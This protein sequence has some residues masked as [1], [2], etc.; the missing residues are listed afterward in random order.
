MNKNKQTSLEKV[1]SSGD[2]SDGPTADYF[3]SSSDYE[4]RSEAACSLVS[5]T[6]TAISARTWPKNRHLVDS[7]PNGE[8]GQWQQ[9]RKSRRHEQETKK[10]AS[11]RDVLIG[12]GLEGSLKPAP[13]QRYGTPVAAGNPIVTGIF[14][15]RLDQRTTPRMLQ[16]HIKAETGLSVRAEK[17]RTKYSTYSSYYIRCDK[18]VRQDL[19]SPYIWPKGILF[20]EFEER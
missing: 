8:H 13:A 16:M 11:Y 5:D 2:M 6:S 1:D 14:I 10:H 20:K 7:S 4:T 15:T 19:L 9:R 18:K 3:Q 12:R 17:L